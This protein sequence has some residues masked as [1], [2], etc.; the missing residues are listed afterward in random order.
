MRLS[1]PPKKLPIDRERIQTQKGTWLVAVETV[2]ESS[3][4]NVLVR[5]VLE[6]AIDDEHFRTRQLGMIVNARE[7]RNPDSV[8]SLANRI[9]NWI[10]STEGDG[11][12]DATGEAI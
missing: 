4:T 5:I 8:Q 11:F 6:Q 10:E 1:L 2:A 9:L 3:S 7:A 12:I